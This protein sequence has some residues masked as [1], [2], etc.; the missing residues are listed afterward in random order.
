MLRTTEYVDWVT[1]IDLGENG[2]ADRPDRNHSTNST[3]WAACNDETCGVA[4]ECLEQRLLMS[5]TEPLA[6]SQIVDMQ[7]DGAVTQV[8]VDEWVV[9][10][11]GAEAKTDPLTTSL[12]EY[13]FDNAEMRSLGGNGFGI[14]TA[15]GTDYESIVAWADLQS[16][17]LYVE[18]NFVH[19]MGD[20][21]ESTSPND[22]SFRWLWGMNNTGQTGGTADAD[23]DAVEAWDLTTG[24]SNVVIAVIDTGVDYTHP[25]LAANMWTNLG[26]IAGDGIDND[27]NGYIDDLHGY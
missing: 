19:T 22:S 23:I 14:I 24:S 26:E 16:D 6:P 13:G 25:D 4:F 21:I 3:Q 2:E 5:G 15:T 7:W 10:F 9:R 8:I 12:L 1:L 17:V 27:G 20:M 18:P 11:D